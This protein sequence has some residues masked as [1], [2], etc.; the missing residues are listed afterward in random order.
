MI[1]PTVIEAI[2]TT[3][4][5]LCPLMHERMRRQWAACEALALARGGVAA[6]AKATGLSRTTIWAGMRALQ[7][8]QSGTGEPLPAARRRAPGGGRLALVDAEPTLLQDLEALVEPTTRGDPQSPLRWT[9][10]STRQLAAELPRQGHPVSYRT[11]AALLHALDYRLPAPRKTREGAS[12]PERNAPFEQINQQGQ[13]FQRRGPPVSSVDAKQKA[14]VGD[15]KNGGR[16]WPP[17]GAP[18]P[19]R[20]HDFEDQTRGKVIPSGVDDPPHNAGWVSVGIDHATAALATKTI[21]RWWQEMG[22]QVSPKATALLVTADA[23]GS[24]SSRSRL[25]KVAVQALAERIRLRISV[26]HWPPGTSKWNKIEHRMF[27]HITNNWRGRPLISRS[28]IV[29]LIGLLAIFGEVESTG[30]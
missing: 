14:W 23:G 6:G 17:Q 30:T 20:T 25:W 12:P 13:A 8:W 16:E 22:R 27:C 26:C 11:V 3:Y 7:H 21:R 10:P 9:C 1:Q 19:V 4:Q 2:H 28:V 24:K 5:R 29:N 18:E 15:F